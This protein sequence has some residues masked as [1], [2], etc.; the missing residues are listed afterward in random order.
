MDLAG[1]E[2]ANKSRGTSKPMTSEMG[3]VPRRQR[4]SKSESGAINA[5]LLALSSC[6]EAL[7]L[8][9]RRCKVR[10]PYRDSKLTRLLTDCLGGNSISCLICCVSPALKHAWQTRHALAFATNTRTIENRVLLNIETASAPMRKKRRLN[11]T[12]RVDS[13]AGVD[14][15]VAAPVTPLKAKTVSGR[16]Q[17]GLPPALTPA[18]NR[19]MAKL[20]LKN[21][22]G[23]VAKLDF[24]EALAIYHFVVSNVL[25]REEYATTRDKILAKMERVRAKQSE[26]TSLSTIEEYTGDTDTSGF[27]DETDAED[28]FKDETSDRLLAAVNG[29]PRHQLQLL[30]YIGRKRANGLVHRRPFDSLSQV[31][32]FLDFGEKRRLAFVDKNVRL[33]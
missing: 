21:A 8:R 23:K 5:S 19:S 1:S 14:G 3:G 13:A 16:D 27:V 11:A 28:V 4:Q 7:S 26:T 25:V 32:A 24:S 17:F 12:S 15:G 29:W 20:Y 33:V 31:L 18:S 30:C 6:I 10:I 9:R 22:K 2:N